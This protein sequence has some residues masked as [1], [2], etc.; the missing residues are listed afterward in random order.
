MQRKLSLTFLICLVGIVCISCSVARSGQRTLSKSELLALVA[1][2]ILSENVVFDIHSRGLAF[3]P[4]A[5][6]KSLLKSAGADDKVLA[7][8][9]VAKTVPSGN[10]ETASDKELLQHLSHAGGLIKSNQLDDAASELTSSLSGGNKSEVGF[11]VGMVLI[12]Q[13]R[14]P[15]AG[16]VYSRILAQDP[17][18][19]E[20]HA[21]LSLTYFA[22]GDSEEALRQAKTALAENPNNAV[23]HVNAGAALQSLQHFDAAKAEYQK[24]IQCKPDYVLAY[25]NLGGLLDQLKDFD[26]AIEQDKKALALDP[27]NIRA[28]Y[29]LGISYANKGDLVS[30][31]REYR[32]VKLRDP[33]NLEARQN[34]GAT[35]MQTD[36]GAAITEFKE[37]AAI[38]PNWPLCH[39]CLGSAY[40]HTERFDEA[41]REYRL[42]IQQNPGSTGPLNGLGTT[43]ETEKKYDE[44]LAL[45][46]QAQDLDSNDAVAYR[47]AGR[48]FVLRKDFASGITDLNRAEQLD[49]ASWI[50]H[51]L[52]GQAL[53][54][55]GDR[56]AAVAEYQQAV[57]LAPK[58]L[59]PRLNL[60]LALEKTGDWVAALNNFHQA[61]I[62]EAPPK[63]NY[64][65]ERRFDAQN[66]YKSAQQRFQQHLADLRT[67]GKSAEA[68]ALAALLKK[69]EAAP[70]LNDKFHAA[71]ENSKQAAM[72]KNFNDA[73]TSAKEAVAIAEKI[74]PQDGRLPEAFGQL[75]NVYM[76]RLDYKDAT[77]AYKRQLALSQQLYGPESPMLATAL[78]SLAM[79]A[80]AQKDFVSAETNFSRALNLNL[81]AYGENSNETATS[82]NGLAGVYFIQK[83]FPKAETVRLRTLKIFETM[84]GESDIRLAIPVGGL[85]HVYDQWNKAEKAAACY[86]RLVSLEEKQFGAASPYL[87]RDLT[88]EAQALRKLGRADEAAKLEQRTQSLQSAANPN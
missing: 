70:N 24:S 48:V 6:Y 67:K 22:T 2:E 7:A 18:F 21:R 41:E 79:L 20:L 33:H 73:E 32:E 29:D 14:F 51:D 75:G 74:Q 17:D 66:Q 65:A 13:E 35:L 4:D 36:P 5:S 23:A 38:A 61:A 11:V 8:L 52:H 86:T 62:D 88:A 55:S 49:P 81:K 39:Q 60:A 83:D 46:Q 45:Y 44:A 47:D 16:K 56:K 34:L 43:L 42:A 77:D 72:A 25:V 64:I 69:S 58:E 87:V 78:Q 71:M 37:L 68:D 27:G 82:L 26:G 15:E 19:P 85:C 54:G 50:N 12:A 9:D 40:L 80:L 10:T 28:R 30:A 1:G 3:V 53:E 31:I 76:W 63:A 84:Y 57:T 59:Q